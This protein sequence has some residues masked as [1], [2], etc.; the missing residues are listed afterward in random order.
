L[1][2]SF[3]QIGRIFDLKAPPLVIEALELRFSSFT[4]NFPGQEWRQQTACA[5][6]VSPGK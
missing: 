3:R 6:R 2:S 5:R 4:N 1:Q